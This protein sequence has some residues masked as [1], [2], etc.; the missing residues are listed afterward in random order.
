MRKM[1]ERF[2]PE[3]AWA[4]SVLADV[5]REK[6]NGTDGEWQQ[7]AM[8]TEQMAEMPLIQQS[9]GLLMRLGLVESLSKVPQQNPTSQCPLVKLVLA[10]S[11]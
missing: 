5:E 10:Q 11:K 1:W 3:K 9:Q 2:T 7:E 6:K 4:R 8:C